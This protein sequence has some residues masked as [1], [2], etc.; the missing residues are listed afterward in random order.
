[1]YAIR[2][3]SPVMVADTTSQEVARRRQAKQSFHTKKDVQA[4]SPS[5]RDSVRLGGCAMAEGVCDLSVHEDRDHGLYI[6][7]VTRP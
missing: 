4:R 5:S 3:G 6:F 2:C 1:M 7:K